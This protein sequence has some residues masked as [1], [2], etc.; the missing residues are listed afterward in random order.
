MEEKIK[1][2][3]NGKNYSFKPSKLAEMVEFY[4][5]MQL[6]SET[7]CCPLCQCDFAD[8]N[9]FVCEEC[10]ELLS[11]EERCEEHNDST[12]NI[13]KSCCKECQQE[14]WDNDS[15]DADFDLYR[16]MNS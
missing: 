12:D 5:K 4:N 10:Q 3:Y 9:L 6:D 2:E 11:T 8:N 13:C 15:I 16:D 7:Y 14:Q 1:F